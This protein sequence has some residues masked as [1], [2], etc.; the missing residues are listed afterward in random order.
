VPQ[1]LKHLLLGVEIE[2][3]F[4]VPRELL[5]FFLI[6]LLNLVFLV[7]VLLGGQI[8]L[9]EVTL[10]DFPP[11]FVHFVGVFIGVGLHELEGAAVAVPQV[12]II[13][14]LVIHIPKPDHVPVFQ[15]VDPGDD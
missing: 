6:D 11:I 12:H 3:G 15:I 14:I 2:F 13:E 8:N 4:P 9:A 1:F 10:P 5:E 7:R